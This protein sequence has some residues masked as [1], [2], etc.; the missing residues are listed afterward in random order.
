V[1]KLKKK[2]K[3][4][5]IDFYDKQILRLLLRKN[6]WLNTNQIAEALDISWNTANKHLIKLFRIGYVIKGR[7]GGLVYYKANY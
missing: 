1:G 2:H 3:I 5:T 6:G 4:Q 7:K